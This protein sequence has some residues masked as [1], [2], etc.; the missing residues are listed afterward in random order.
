MS[1]FILREAKN[2]GNL[3]GEIADKTTDNFLVVSKE[4]GCSNCSCLLDYAKRLVNNYQHN[5]SKD[6]KIIRYL[7]D[8]KE[9]AEVLMNYDP[10]NKEKACFKIRDKLVF[11]PTIIHF[12]DKLE[13]KMHSRYEGWDEEFV[14][15]FILNDRK[16]TKK[17]Y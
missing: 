8:E 6:I 2:I 17:K 4:R 1:N 13:E 16:L 15:L 11:A 12:D 5:G 7:I 10:T 3:N 14:G 9:D